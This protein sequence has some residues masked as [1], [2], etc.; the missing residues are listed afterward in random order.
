M[1]D[2]HRQSSS[3]RRGATALEEVMCLAVAISVAVT[4]FF[5]TR[6]SAQYVF[7]IIVTLV[8]WPYL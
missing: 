5:L 2:C 1:S 8:G 3:S 4:L 6:S 7:Q